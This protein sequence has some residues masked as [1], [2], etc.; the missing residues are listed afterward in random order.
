[1]GN[2][3]EDGSVMY[4]VIYGIQHI[5][6]YRLCMQCMISEQ[7]HTE[8]VLCDSVFAVIFF[9]KMHNKI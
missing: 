3:A 2:S 7:C 8:C 1:M 6:L 4:E 5:P 9:H